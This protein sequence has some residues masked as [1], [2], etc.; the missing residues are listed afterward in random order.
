MG[1]GSP[2]R[3]PIGS[4]PLYPTTVLYIYLYLQAL[5]KYTKTPESRQIRH[6]MLTVE[7]HW[8]RIMGAGGLGHL[9]RLDNFSL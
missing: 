4:S 6:L 3:V 1:C 9:I 5:R 8:P 2:A 7:V